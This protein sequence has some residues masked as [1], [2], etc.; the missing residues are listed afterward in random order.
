MCS[1][2]GEE[3]IR[4]WRGQHSWRR[5]G[6]LEPL[7]EEKSKFLCCSWTRLTGGQGDWGSSVL[8]GFARR[9]VHTSSNDFW[10]RQ[11]SL[12]EEVLAAHLGLPFSR[13]LCWGQKVRQSPKK[14]HPDWRT[15][16]VWVLV[17][18]TYKSTF[19]FRFES[20]IQNKHH[21]L[22]EIFGQWKSGDHGLC[23]LVLHAAV[24]IWEGTQS[25]T[26]LSNKNSEH[27]L[28]LTMCQGTVLNILHVWINLRF[29]TTH[30]K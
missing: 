23:F 7:K 6:S 15:D 19:Q 22:F 5:R 1:R 18:D 4:D 12:R 9:S 10:Q 27:L 14:S 30:M 26:F 28:A 24:P 20:G 21:L 17:W 11:L 13:L 8:P 25:F 2:E 29:L 3:A 16:I